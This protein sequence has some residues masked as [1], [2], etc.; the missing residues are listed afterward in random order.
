MLQRGALLLIFAQVVAVACSSSSDE[1]AGGGDA[2]LD[3]SSNPDADSGS[4]A[5]ADGDASGCL[6]AE[7]TCGNACVS[8]GDC[9]HAVTADSP[10]S[11]KVW[12]NGATFLRLAL[13]NADDVDG[14]RVA[15]ATVAFRRADSAHLWLE[16]PPGVA[17]DADV[18]L[19]SPAGDTITK[20]ALT[21]RSGAEGLSWTTKTM[22]SA[23]GGFP[24][25]ATT[26]DDRALVAGGYT[27][28]QVPACTD[29]ADLFEKASGASTPAANAMSTKRWTASATTMLD[30][31]TLLAGA[32]YVLGSGCPYDS[33]ALDLFDPTS[34]AFTPSQ[35]KL[36]IPRSY[37][38]TLLLAD[39]RVLIGS[40]ETP[41]FEIYDPETDAT[42]LVSGGTFSTLSPVV[43]WMARLR[44]G[45]VLVVPGGGGPNSIFDPAA[46]SFTPT[47]DSLA[48][49][50]DALV[51]VG[52]G[53]VFAIGGID[54]ST[55]AGTLMQ[56]TSGAI[57]VFDPA[58][59]KFAP[60]SPSLATSRT[61]S[62]AVLA[63][64]GVIYVIGGMSGT[65]KLSI[66]C[67][68]DA[69]VAPFTFLTSVEMIDPVAATVTTGPSLP[70]PN[71]SLRSTI[72]YDGSII[73]GGGTP[74]GSK[75]VSY[76]S[77]YFLEAPPVR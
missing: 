50:P 45:R 70:E 59:G 77:V 12:V 48:R 39:G 17:G 11:A 38:R 40:D 30:G 1:P 18:T 75:A 74:C 5:P 46:G 24:A 58:A 52:D 68:N 31:K 54:V 35:A 33:T 27:V 36:G 53:R 26:F 7:T 19:H 34:N 57:D 15:D 43:G 64:D 9:A 42:Q 23:R 72:L 76:P 56:A 21:Y 69:D 61:G 3:A 47:G 2:G 67:A 71:I 16:I 41:P 8:G 13:A 51:A 55:Q 73:A 22:T 37:L 14:A 20:R 66:S 6:G 32:C 63:R 29:T 25:M 62:T 4:D 49:Y 44:D 60:W 28:P 10:D 65:G